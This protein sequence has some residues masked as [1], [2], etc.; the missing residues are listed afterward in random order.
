VIPLTATVVV[1]NSRVSHMRLWIPLFLVW[2]MLIPVAIVLSPVFLI[3]CLVGEVNPFTALSVIFG[4]IGSLKGTHV[5]VGDRRSSLSL[6]I[7]IP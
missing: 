6:L 4:I 1:S 5:N 7:D 2:L 3:A